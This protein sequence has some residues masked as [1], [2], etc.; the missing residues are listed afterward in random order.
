MLCGGGGAENINT[1]IHKL[2][3]FLCS[4]AKQEFPRQHKL[5]H[6]LHI[7][8]TTQLE[9]YRVYQGVK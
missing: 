8:L 6:T 2:E 7:Q 9:G 1:H 3:Q 4:S 5:P